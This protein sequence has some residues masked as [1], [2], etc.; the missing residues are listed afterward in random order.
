MRSRIFALLAVVVSVCAILLLS[1]SRKPPAESITIPSKVPD[2]DT[3]QTSQGHEA[4]TIPAPTFRT[5]Q[6]ATGRTARP[7]DGLLN[8]IDSTP[9]SQNSSPLWVVTMYSDE[10]DDFS[11]LRATSQQALSANGISI[12]SLTRNSAP[13]RTNSELFM[14]TAA[15]LETL[16][17]Y[18]DGLIMGKLKVHTVPSD[19][20]GGMFA[21]HLSADVK[22][23]STSNGVRRELVI[24]E[25][26][27]GFDAST[28]QSNAE[29]RLAEKLKTE[30]AHF[31]FR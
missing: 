18:C 1:Y 16:K 13:I 3:G 23:I 30:L 14:A 15:T 31:S 10:G 11:I 20:F 25:D 9:R 19:Q 22:L 21:T 7:K 28:S 17:P 27:G 8:S 29:R 2:K 4:P 5:T 12:T 26:G 6:D 24:E